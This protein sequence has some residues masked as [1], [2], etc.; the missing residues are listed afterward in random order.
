MAAGKHA[1]DSQWR[2]WRMNFLLSNS[3]L[4]LSFSL[5]ITMSS[6]PA[7]IVNQNAFLKCRLP[8]NSCIDLMM[9]TQYA[10]LPTPRLNPTAAP[11]EWAGY[12]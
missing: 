5:S 3:F 6:P 12:N 7:P 1:T 2:S 8:R 9:I 11:C 4:S 10:M